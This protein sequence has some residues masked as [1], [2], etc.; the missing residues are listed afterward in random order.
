MINRELTMDKR[1]LIAIKKINSLKALIISNKKWFVKHNCG[2]HSK[3][4]F[5]SLIAQIFKPALFFF[6]ILGPLC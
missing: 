5:L 4:V 2:F 1:W 3:N 6:V